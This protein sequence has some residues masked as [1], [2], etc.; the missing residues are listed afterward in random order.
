MPKRW[1]VK[2]EPSSYAFDDLEDEGRTIWDGVKNNLALIHLRAMKKGD[3][4]V[5]Y[6]SGRER[7]AVGVARVAR[8]PYPD[9]QEDDDRV[10]VVDLEPLRRLDRPVPLG[11]LKEEAA[12][13]DWELIT[14][15]RLS[16]M[17]VPA[18]A[19]RELKARAKA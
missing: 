1:L 14:M 12:L 15:P 4:V 8:G 13:E 7:A 3:E 17:P 10:V 6:H 9:P 18:P 5:V 11:E 16:V 19:W 2:T